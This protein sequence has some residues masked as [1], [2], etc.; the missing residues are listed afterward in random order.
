[1]NWTPRRAVLS[2]IFSLLEFCSLCNAEFVIRVP[3][4]PLVAI[5]G[6]STV[7]SCTFPVGGAFDLASSIITWQRHLEVVHSFYHGRDQLDLQSRRYANRT[8]LYHSELG[9]GNASLWLDRT[10]P[11]DAGEYTCSIST[12]I[13]SQKKSF[14][15]KIAAFYTEPH[16]QVTTSPQGVEL[17]LTSRGYPTPK[18][19][20]L[21]G[22]GAELSNKTQTALLRDAQGLYEVSSSL[23][24]ERGA[25]STLI[26][27]LQNRDL[28]QEIRRE[29]SLQSE[30]AGISSHE[31]RSGPNAVLAVCLSAFLM[32]GILGI[33]L[34]LWKRKCFPRP[35]PEADREEASSE[36]KL[37]NGTPVHGWTS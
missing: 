13:G 8:S 23:T 33:M 37:V 7:L 3:R 36:Q 6:H 2:F 21:D 24:Q 15:L 34:F 11:E 9:R 27:I 4:A 17:K 25:N 28:G 20:W 19:R 22:T 10:N 12:L 26:F 31:S 16:L 32:L 14:P 35:D 1:M 29:F 30:A 5:H 18:V